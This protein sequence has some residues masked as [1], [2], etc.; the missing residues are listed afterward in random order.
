MFS[1]VVVV[2]FIVVVVVSVVV[3]AVVVVCGVDMHKFVTQSSV[4]PPEAVLGLH[5]FGESSTLAKLLLVVTSGTQILKV[6]DTALP[7]ALHWHS[8]HSCIN[9]L[10]GSHILSSGKRLRIMLK[11]FYI[12]INR[13]SDV[14]SSAARM[15]NQNGTHFSVRRRLSYHLGC[16]YTEDTLSGYRI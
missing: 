15:R 9:N 2:V 3:A 13:R 7:S 6:H 4:Q 1:A 8:L 12:W 11:Q 10:P 5:F 16:R 14:I